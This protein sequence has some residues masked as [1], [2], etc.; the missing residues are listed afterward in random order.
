MNTQV[1]FITLLTATVALM[2]TLPA[3]VAPPVI[4][5]SSNLYE[6]YIHKYISRCQTKEALLKKLKLKNI[7]KIVSQAKKKAVFLSENKEQLIGEMIEKKIGEKQYLIKL[8][9]NKRF[10]EMAPAN[11]MTSPQ[12]IVALDL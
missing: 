7:Q 3:A 9:L 4:D 6:A 10:H 12:T 8:Y 5:E 2:S 1:F 11:D